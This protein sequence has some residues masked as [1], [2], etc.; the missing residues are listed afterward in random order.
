MIQ[1]VSAFQILIACVRKTSFFGL[2]CASHFFV[3]VAHFVFLRDVWIRTQ[4]ASVASRR[5]TNLATHL[6]T[7]TVNTCFNITLSSQ[8]VVLSS[9]YRYFVADPD[10]R[11]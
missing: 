3:Y 8:S 6:N 9:E 7:E 4:R 10:P 1:I 5:A 11:I 2:V